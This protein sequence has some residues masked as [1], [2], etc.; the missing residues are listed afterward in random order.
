MPY[1]IPS[2][3]ITRPFPSRNISALVIPLVLALLSAAAFVFHFVRKKRLR[4][5]T[6]AGRAATSL[7]EP[8]INSTE[9]V[10]IP[11]NELQSISRP[12]ELHGSEPKKIIQ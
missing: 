2:P 9:L 11:V 12:F 3:N 7:A 1:E 5:A 6:T 4:K 8:Q 10:G